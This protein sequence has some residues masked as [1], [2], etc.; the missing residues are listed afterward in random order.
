MTDTAIDNGGGEHRGRARE[1][2]RE[3]AVLSL[4]VCCLLLGTGLRLVASATAAPPA[5]AST[6]CAAK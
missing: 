1:L 3:H 5:G 4:V 2:L 6:A